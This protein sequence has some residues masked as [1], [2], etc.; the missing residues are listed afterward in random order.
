MGIVVMTTTDMLEVGGSILMTKLC[1]CVLPH[2]F[3]VRIVRGRNSVPPLQWSARSLMPLTQAA[4]AA[5]H[6]VPEKV[7]ALFYLRRKKNRIN[8]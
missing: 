4:Y 2:F 1:L 6:T 3:W 5:V 7:I 8:S